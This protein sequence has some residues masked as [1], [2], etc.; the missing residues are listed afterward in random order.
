MKNAIEVN[1]ISKKLKNFSLTNV[2][3]N[4]ESGTI[5]G[6]VGE[7]G[8]GKT[9]TIKAILNMIKCD[10]GSINIFGTD[11][12]KNESKIKEDI[13]IVFDEM[14]FNESLNLTSMNK[15]MKTIYKQWDEQIFKK[16]CQRLE[17]PDDKPFKTFSKGMKMKASIACAM[18][19]NA[20]LLILD[21]PTSGIDPIMKTEVLDMF[22]EFVSDEEHSI[23]ISS[24]ITN[25]LE[26]IADAITFI[27]K[28][29]ILL[30]EDKLSML[31]RHK[32]IKCTPQALE[33][34]D[35]SSIIGY[36]KSKFD[37]EVLVNDATPYTTS[38]FVIDQPTIEQI[39]FFYAKNF[40][41]STAKI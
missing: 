31:E 18:S 39:M 11:H 21:E 34:I 22:Q 30:C 13:G 4:V 26:R 12:I 29:Q 36:R 32:L 33:T 16:H 14:C 28:G 19:H 1:F 3:F 41:S 27:H 8:A 5:M 23:L 10:Y 24:H 37:C 40:K 17:L 6:F 20:K 7:N 2:S 38:D 9:T 25:D 15:I 35:S